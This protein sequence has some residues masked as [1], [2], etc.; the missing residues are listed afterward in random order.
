M[1]S[2]THAR[3][4]GSSA[5]LGRN[6]PI[7]ASSAFSASAC[8]WRPAFSNASMLSRRC[9][10]RRRSSFSQIS[11]GSESALSFFIS[12]RNAARMARS[13]VS[14]AASLAFMASFI[15]VV[16]AS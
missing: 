9:F 14:R 16:I 4:V 6:S 12:V 11:S 10:S 2:F 13:A 15:W 1:A 7:T 8:S 5:R 3:V